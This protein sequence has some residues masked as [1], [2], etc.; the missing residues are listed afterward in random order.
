[1]LSE[2]VDGLVS[3]QDSVCG[4]LRVI[5]RRTFADTGTFWTYQGQ[6]SSRDNP[7]YVEIINV[8]TATS[9]VKVVSVQ[10]DS[11]YAVPSVL[12]V[13]CNTLVGAYVSFW[14]V[15]DSSMEWSYRVR[16]VRFVGHV[17]PAL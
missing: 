13:V 5:E 15:Y 17:I 1:M 6:V 4:M 2:C 12:H 8:K 9:V 3:P 16:Y 11:S 7:I 10:S 14:M